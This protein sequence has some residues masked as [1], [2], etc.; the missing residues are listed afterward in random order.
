MQRAKPE[1][2]EGHPRYEKVGVPQT[3]AMRGPAARRGRGMPSDARLPAA[4]AVWRAPA[5]WLACLQIRDLNSGTF[6]FVQLARDKQSGEL[7]AIKFIERGDKVRRL[8]WTH[9][10]HPVTP[11]GAPAPGDKTAGLTPACEPLRR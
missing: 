6:G 7:T 9:I 3:P 1:P 2:L 11:A 5:T 4:C 8:A 10:R